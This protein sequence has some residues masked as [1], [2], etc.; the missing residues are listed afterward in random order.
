MKFITHRHLTNQT[1]LGMFT[2]LWPTQ[3][4]RDDRATTG[5]WYLHLHIGTFRLEILG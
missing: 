2:N 5:G 1:R 4:C 3:L